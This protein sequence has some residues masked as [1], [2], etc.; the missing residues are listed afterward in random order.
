MANSFEVTRLLYE[1]MCKEYA[2]SP[3]RRLR[4]YAGYLDRFLHSAETVDGT[5]AED[6][7]DRL[8]MSYNRYFAG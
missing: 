3:Y 1:D 6:R 4:E 2:T 8:P 7:A 5:S